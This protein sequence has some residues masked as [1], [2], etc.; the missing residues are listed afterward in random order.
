MLVTLFS[1]ISRFHFLLWKESLHF[2][3]RTKILRFQWGS[4]C[5]GSVNFPALHVIL[6]HFIVFTSVHFFLFFQLFLSF[7]FLLSF[8]LTLFPDFR[9]STSM[10]LARFYHFLCTSLHPNPFG[11]SHS[12]S[13]FSFY[14]FHLKLA[15]SYVLSSVFVSLFSLI[16]GF[17]FLSFNDW[18]L[19]KLY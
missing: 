12:I 6:F 9:I 1:L 4:I 19:P 5:Q 17:Y 10:I 2:I 3:E 11:C 15:L 16:S 8:R 18:N 14:F 13:K 7:F